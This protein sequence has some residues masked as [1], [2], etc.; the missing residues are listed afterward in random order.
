MGDKQL[1][2]VFKHTVKEIENGS[3]GCYKRTNTEFTYLRSQELKELAKT[4]DVKVVGVTRLKPY[5][6]KNNDTHEEIVLFNKT[7]TDVDGKETVVTGLTTELKD[8]KGL[9]WTTTGYLQVGFKTYIQLC[10]S[11]LI[12]L[13]ILLGVAAGITTT[14]LYEPPP[15]PYVETDPDYDEDQQ[16]WDEDVVKNG[17]DSEPAIDSTTF[18]GY[19]VLYIANA[20][21]TISLVNPAV[22]TVDFTYSIVNADGE[23]LYTTSKIRPGKY[24]PLAIG[25]LYSEYGSYAMSFVVKTYDIETGVEC[26]S[27]TMPVV[28][29]VGTHIHEH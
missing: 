24:V 26:T 1:K 20:T 7:V 23:E 6:V 28:L 11:L 19:S 16:N 14:V 29:N 17:N 2:G 21:E 10:K 15:P 13:L 4:T 8:R 3:K 9:F 22:N 18:P 27:V 5:K 12:P 25:K